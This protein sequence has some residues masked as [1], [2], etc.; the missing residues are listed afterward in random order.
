MASYRR[1]VNSQKCV[2]AGGKHN[3]LEDVG[4]DMY[5]HT[6]FEML[7]NWSFGDYFKVWLIISFFYW[8]F[9]SSLWHQDTLRPLKK[10]EKSEREEKL[11]VSLQK[12]WVPQRNLVF[13]CKDLRSLT[14][15]LRSPLFC[16]FAKV[17]HFQRKSKVLT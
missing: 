17:T 1:V 16:F 5:H 4:K 9:F 12:Y 10:Y 8:G 7:G 11:S 15:V 14:K 2:R 3:D 13:S 6:F